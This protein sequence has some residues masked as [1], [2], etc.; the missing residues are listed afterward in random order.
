MPMTLPRETTHSH[1]RITKYNAVYDDF[2][3]QMLSYLGWLK[4]SNPTKWNVFLPRWIP[5]VVMVSSVF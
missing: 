4:V 2:S 1:G 3:P 5:I